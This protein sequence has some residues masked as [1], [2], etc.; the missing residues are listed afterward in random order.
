MGV[1]LRRRQ[2]DA[3]RGLLKAPPA[4]RS[5]LTSGS[6]GG[7]RLHCTKTVWGI[8]GLMPDNWVS[9]PLSKGRS[10]KP[11]QKRRKYSVNRG[12]TQTC[13]SSY[14]TCLSWALTRHRDALRCA[15][16]VITSDDNYAHFHLNRA[17]KEHFQFVRPVLSG[18]P[19][20]WQLTYGYRWHHRAL[21]E[22]SDPAILR[23]W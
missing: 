2:E 10:R 12:F 7:N 20:R 14:L 13:I 16:Y 4:P 23:T 9:P 11:Q 22:L 19:L 3:D 5:E 21:R 17:T 6:T 8:A 1:A 18:H 15:F